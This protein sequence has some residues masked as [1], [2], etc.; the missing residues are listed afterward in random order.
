MNRT[1]LIF[2]MI[3]TAMI[4][5]VIGQHEPTAQ[6]DTMPWEVDKLKNGSL[7]VFG[8]TLSKTSIQDANQIFA[9]FAETRLQVT[10]DASE[11]KTYQLIADYNELII[12][13]LIAKISLTYQLNQK[14]LEEIAHSIKNVENTQGR[15]LYSINNKIEMSYLNTAISTITYIPSID[16]GLET[17]RQNFGQATEEK[18]IDE[19]LQ[20]WTYPEMGLQV[21]IYKSELDHFVY[22]ALK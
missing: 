16:Y 5:A 2:L 20:I 12:G 18:Q 6:L 4:V 7:R 21:Y 10:T 11:R 22:A 1:F 19:E 9:S 13:G 17:I 3:G 14:A 15:H 8:I